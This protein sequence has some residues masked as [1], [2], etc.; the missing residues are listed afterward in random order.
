MASKKAFNPFYLL[1]V[2]VGTTFVVTA[3]A[4]GMMA[5]LQTMPDPKAAARLEHPLWQLMSTYGNVLLIAEIILL[6]IFSFAAMGTDSYWTRRA[7]KT[8]DKS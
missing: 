6:A 7:E 1:L 3:T 5:Y 8:A 2:I 4:Y